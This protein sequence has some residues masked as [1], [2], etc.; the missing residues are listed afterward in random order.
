MSVEANKKLVVET[1]GCVSRG[2]LAGFLDGLADDVTWT[3]F[4]RHRFA[5]TFRGKE[6]VRNGLFAPLGAVLA[7][8]IVVH[9]DTLT[10]E[11]DRVVV[12]ARGE[13]ATRTGG[14]YDN[15]YCL[16]VTVREGR[17]AHIREYLDTELV[18][19]VFGHAP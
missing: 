15:Q 2:D 17:I 10:A 7:D 16:V 4:G 19:A 9:I 1:W 13:A 6:A 3:F 14:R 5:G 8:G 11:G 18:S 12:E